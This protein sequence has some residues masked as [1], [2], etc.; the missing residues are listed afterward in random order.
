MN[1]IEDLMLSL[2]KEKKIR[3]ID[4]KHDYENGFFFGPHVHMNVIEDSE[5]IKGFY[6]LKV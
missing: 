3:R 1:K 2:E 4:V 5:G 6:F